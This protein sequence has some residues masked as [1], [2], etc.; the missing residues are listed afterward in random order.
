ML[1]PLAVGLFG[2]H[3]KQN[4][5]VTEHVALHSALAKLLA[6]VFRCLLM[7]RLEY[8]RKKEKTCVLW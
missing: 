5:A 6:V 7:N 4:T 2:P 1:R 3:S 8:Q